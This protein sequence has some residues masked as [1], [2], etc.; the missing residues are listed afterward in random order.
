MFVSSFLLANVILFSH[1]S[2]SNARS[3]LL[4]SIRTYSTIQPYTHRH[5]RLVTMSTKPVRRPTFRTRARDDNRAFSLSYGKYISNDRSSQRSGSRTNNISS[6]VRRDERALT[7]AWSSFHLPYNVMQILQSTWSPTANFRSSMEAHY[8]P[9]LLLFFCHRP[10]RLVV[11][12][13]RLPPALRIWNLN[14]LKP[15]FS[16][17]WFI[18]LHLAMVQRLRVVRW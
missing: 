16:R 12:C 4:S 5:F 14:L 15:Q 2:M 7:S 10:R 18:L 8:Y 13:Q 9:F 11:P 3:N 6:N 17:W 1:P